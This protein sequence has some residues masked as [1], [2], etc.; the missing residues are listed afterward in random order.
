MEKKTGATSFSI[1]LHYQPEMDSCLSLWVTTET[2][3]GI[4]IQAQND[5]LFKQI[6]DWSG[7]LNHICKWA[8]KDIHYWA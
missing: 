1:V 7:K 3:Y 8:F 5:I 2:A 4:V 6:R